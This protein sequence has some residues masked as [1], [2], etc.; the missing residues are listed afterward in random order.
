MKRTSFWTKAREAFFGSL[1]TCRLEPP[2][3]TSQQKQYH[4]THPFLGCF[5]WLPW[6]W[7][8]LTARWLSPIIPTVICIPWTLSPF[9]R[10]GWHWTGWTC[11]WWGVVDMEKGFGYALIVETPDDGVLECRHHRVGER[12]LA[13]PQIGW[14][15]QKGRFAYPRRIVYHFIAQGGYVSIAKTYRVYARGKGLLVTLREKAKRN[16]DL[17]KLFG[18]ADVWGVWGVNYEQFVQEAKLLGVD[19]LILHGTARREAMQRAVEVGYLTSEY[20]NYTDIL[21]VDSEQKIDS[22]HDLLPDSAGTES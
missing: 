17:R 20:D 10:A 12:E 2:H 9:P 7:T 19:K 3:C 13:A 14:W 16:P 1:C 15:A 5:S 4:L 18:A 11:R 21:P 6:C 8:L 22:N